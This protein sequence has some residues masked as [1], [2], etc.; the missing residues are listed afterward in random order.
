MN[1]NT[2]NYVSVFTICGSPI[3]PPLVSF[4]SMYNSNGFDST[5]H[6]AF[7]QYKKMTDQIRNE[8]K[9]Y[10]ERAMAIERRLYE[11]SYQN[12][13]TPPVAEEYIRSETS[14]SKTDD[15]QGS[16]K[17]LPDFSSV[18]LID[19]SESGTSVKELAHSLVEL[20]ST[21]DRLE[22]QET[23]LSVCDLLETRS[24]KVFSE[25]SIKFTED[26]DADEVTDRS[27]RPPTP[28]LIRSNSYTLDTPSPLL[29][30]FM[31][32]KG[33][34]M[35][36][37][38]A[39][40]PIASKPNVPDKQTTNNVP[41]I[42]IQSPIV[43]VPSPFIAKPAHTKANVRSTFTRDKIK[44]KSQNNR[45]PKVELPKRATATAKSAAMVYKTKTAAT[46]KD[47]FSSTP[48]VMVE[49]KTSKQ[50][51]AIKPKAAPSTFATNDMKSKSTNC[52]GHKSP[53]R[54][55]S[56]K[57]SNENED[58]ILQFLRNFEEERNA[59]MLDL[60][61][62][63]KVEQKQMHDSFLVQQQLLVQQITENCS[64]IF[65]GNCRKATAVA[66]TTGAQDKSVTM[67]P[68]S[69]SDC[70]SYATTSSVSKI[71]KRISVSPNTEVEADVINNNSTKKPMN[72]GDQQRPTPGCNRRLFGETMSKES[73]AGS[74]MVM[75]E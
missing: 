24:L 10:K 20:D 60:I 26:T 42:T 27:I 70:S 58:K 52:L 63:Q 29:V 5:V 4:H 48:L 74:T 17:Y 37:T 73:V 34:D 47:R 53:Q 7:I 22:D 19:A 23:I 39:A 67:S 13:N 54:I 49:G 41:T 55:A 1:V 38:T 51:M 56:P 8:M 64:N 9:L 16:E 69:S 62:R 12:R 45:K 46:A 21:S 68:Y 36:T 40:H 15:I 18:S 71:P 28:R 3:L 61:E 72:G 32:L 11:K 30:K 14:L 6:F 2:G 57:H 31:Q 65:G 25:T 75:L 66:A 43:N 50:V 35:P 33:I 44:P 59:Q